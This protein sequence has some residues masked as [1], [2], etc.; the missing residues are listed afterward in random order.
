MD[1]PELVNLSLFNLGE[2]QTRRDEA[3]AAAGQRLR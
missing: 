2:A 1:G 3:A